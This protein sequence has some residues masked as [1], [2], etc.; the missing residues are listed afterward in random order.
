MRTL[1]RI[2]EYICILKIF[3]KLLPG[4]KKDGFDCSRARAYGV[5]N[6]V[7]LC[8]LCPRGVSEVVQL[9]FR[10]VKPCF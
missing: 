5:Q 1:G 2:D 3:V 6:E 4:A 7:E 9:S 10:F 8:S